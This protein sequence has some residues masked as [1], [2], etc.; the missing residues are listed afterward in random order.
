MFGGYLGKDLSPP[1]PP[2]PRVAPPPRPR[3]WLALAPYPP[4][5]AVDCVSVCR[6]PLALLAVC[7]ALFT[8]IKYIYHVV[9]F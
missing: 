1:P 7:I 3:S 5:V 6:S 4:L 2:P 9:N 8:L